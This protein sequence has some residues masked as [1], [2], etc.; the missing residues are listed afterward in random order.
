MGVIVAGAITFAAGGINL[1]HKSAYPLADYPLDTFVLQVGSTATTAGAAE[2]VT[3]QHG[4]TGNIIS[5]PAPAQE[6][7]I[8]LMI[9]ST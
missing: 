4:I 8:G 5:A 6:H 7:Y 3:V 9:H 2:A 1:A